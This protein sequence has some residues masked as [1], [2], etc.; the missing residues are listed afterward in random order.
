MNKN[1]K[2]EIDSPDSSE[3]ELEIQNITNNKH[4]K[5]QQQQSP[6][7]SKAPHQQIQIKNTTHNK[8]TNSNYPYLT[9]DPAH[10]EIHN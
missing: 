1:N 3:N 5:Q 10:N 4:N 6:R 8:V 2:I 7:S 9:Y